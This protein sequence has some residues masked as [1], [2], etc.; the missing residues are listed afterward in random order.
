MSPAILVEFP[1]QRRASLQKGNNLNDRAVLSI[2][3]P[4]QACTWRLWQLSGHEDG[5]G[6]DNFGTG[7]NMLI[8]RYL[9]ELVPNRE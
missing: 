2:Y 9:A 7:F 1:L 3:I 5:R 8:D 6:T 4:T